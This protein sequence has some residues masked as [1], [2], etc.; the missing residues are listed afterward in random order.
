[1]PFFWSP[2]DLHTRSEESIVAFTK[3]R[4]ELL[5]AVVKQQVAI[6]R[7]GPDA[8]RILHEFSPSEEDAEIPSQEDVKGREDFL[9]R[10]VDK[11]RKDEAKTAEE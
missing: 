5:N 6:S 3:L 2:A 11:L 9:H 8:S 4:A 7:M 10:I 1:M